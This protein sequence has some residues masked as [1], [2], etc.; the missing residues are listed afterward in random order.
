DQAKELEKR[1]RYE[2]SKQ[3]INT[4]STV[5]GASPNASTHFE[6][7]VAVDNDDTSSQ[8]NGKE[9]VAVDPR[10]RPTVAGEQ[11][12]NGD[13]NNKSN[14][15]NE[16]R[17]EREKGDSGEGSS[18]RK[19]PT[20]SPTN[21]NASSTM[22]NFFTAAARGIKQARVITEALEGGPSRASH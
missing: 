5:S 12:T 15:S 13:N 8:T 17:S 11:S 3:D 22:I 19:H 9:D 1:R 4:F 14:S 21:G 16:T 2:L 7:G 10:G 20:G 18:P 6:N